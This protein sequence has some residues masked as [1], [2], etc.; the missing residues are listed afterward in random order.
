MLDKVD[1]SK[2]MGQNLQTWDTNTE[3]LPF[4]IVFAVCGLSKWL[5]QGVM[6]SYIYINTILP[7][8]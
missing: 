5:F 3:I 6:D 7:E 1:G 2:H 8:L 4:P